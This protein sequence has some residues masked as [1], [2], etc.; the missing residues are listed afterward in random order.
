MRHDITRGP[1]KEKPGLG[2]FIEVLPALRDACR[3]TTEYA[4][5]K[6]VKTMFENHG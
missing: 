3:A 6:G 1:D 2:D 4:C 5:D